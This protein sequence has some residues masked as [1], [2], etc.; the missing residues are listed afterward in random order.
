MVI[1]SFVAALQ[2][3]VEPTLFYSITNAGSNWWS[4][5]QLGYSFA[6]E[7]GE[8]GQAATVSVVLLVLSGIAAVVFITR[9]GFFQTEVDA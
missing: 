7:Q 9:S 1:L 6:F 3:F 5:N 4:L 8:F 2:S